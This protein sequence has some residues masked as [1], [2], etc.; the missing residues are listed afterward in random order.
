MDLSFL[1]DSGGL[2]LPKPLQDF[3]GT[4]VVGDDASTF[5]FNTLVWSPFRLRTRRG[6][7]SQQ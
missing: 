7:I 5:L 2:F 3:L 6:T 4:Y 1:R